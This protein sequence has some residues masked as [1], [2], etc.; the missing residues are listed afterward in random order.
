MIITL[1]MDQFGNFNN[2]TTA[3]AMRFAE[4]LKEHGHTLRIVTCYDYKAE[5][6]YKTPAIK[7]PVFQKL[8]MSQG[9]CFAKPDDKVLYEAIKGADVVHLML[10]FFVQKRALQIAKE[11]NVP[12]TTAFHCQPENI[13]YTIHMENW[14][15]LNKKI[16]RWFNNSFYKNIKH[17]HCPS[18]MIKQQ[19]ELNGYHNEFHVISNGV[20]P[21]FV[22]KKVE[23]PACYKNKF[24]IVMVGRYSREK[25]QDLIVEAITKSKYRDHIQ[26]ILCGQGPWKGYLES[27]SL[28]LKNPIVFKFCKKDELIETLNYCDLYVHASDAEIEA[29]SCIEAFA[30]GLVPIISNSSISATSQFALEDINKFNKGDSTDLSRKIDYFIEHPAKKVELSKRY[31][32]FSKQYALDGCVKQLEDVF[33]MAIKENQGL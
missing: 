28:R 19:L 33:E 24:L 7:V 4:V 9:M 26:L 2:G 27:L 14:K 10:P 15:W 6:V 17:V 13:T 32:E 21:S 3:T 5:N 16:Y 20:S 30:T 8:I 31:V 23:R 29:I 1:I 18:N 12:V 25:R 22:P 11:L